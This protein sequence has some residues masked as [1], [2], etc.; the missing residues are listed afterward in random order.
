MLSS[1][2]PSAKR[3]ALVPAVRRPIEAPSGTQLTLPFDPPGRFFIVNMS[4]ATKAGFVEFLKREQPRILVDVRPVPSFSLDTFSRR[5]AFQLFEAH[6][7]HYVDLGNLFREGT[8]SSFH[9]LTRAV[10]DR[11]TRA[12]D[13]LK[14]NPDGVGLLL[15]A[16]SVQAWTASRLHEAIRPVPKYGWRLQLVPRPQLTL[17]R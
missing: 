4:I 14:V 3:L 6:K 9:Y 8:A 11:M 2:P 5:S 10:A 17:L 15:E 13:S 1:P 16:S 7:V 12:L